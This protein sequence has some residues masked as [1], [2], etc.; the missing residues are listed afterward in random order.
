MMHVTVELSPRAAWC[1]GTNDSTGLLWDIRNEAD[2]EVLG[3]PRRRLHLRV[4]V[5]R[6]EVWLNAAEC[7]VRYGATGARDHEGQGL[8]LKEQRALARAAAALRA[9]LAEAVPGR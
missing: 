7:A 4:P 2:V 5:G 8:T 6:A 1:L 3:P 9:A